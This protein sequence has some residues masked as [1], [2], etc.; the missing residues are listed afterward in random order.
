MGKGKKLV[1][2]LL[3][4][5]M[6][7]SLLAGASPFTGANA[8]E[9]GQTKEWGKDD[10]SGLRAGDTVLFGSYEQDNDLENGAE[11]IEWIA[12]SVEGDKALLLSK[13]ALE[14]SSY[15]NFYDLLERFPDG[16]GSVDWDAVKITWEECTLRAWL[17]ETF[18]SMA[19]TAEQREAVIE[20]VLENAYNPIYSTD[21]GNDTRDCV[22]LL[23]IEDVLNP[24][25]GFDESM[26]MYDV[27]RRC[28][29]T[30]YV[31]A[32]GLWTLDMAYDEGDEG[33]RD[34]ATAEGE[35]PCWWWLRSSGEDES[36]AAQ[37]H[38]YGY[39]SDDYMYDEEGAVRPAIY[40][41]LKS[42]Q[43]SDPVKKG[44]VDGDGQINSKDVTQL[45]RYLAGGWNVEINMVNADV[46][47]DGEVNSKDV[48]ILRRFLAGGWGVVL[49]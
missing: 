41:D 9:S 43:P 13:Y 47:G 44:D 39:V 15:E 3:A 37:V 6:M 28:S 18:Y 33:W 12:L 8:L 2:L 22:F 19:F 24:D 25:Y 7:T 27:A 42:S 38:C 30:E 17:N 32:Q 48:T 20:T 46:N 49:E 5:V 11:P 21:G 10:L 1:G 36:R 29:G 40:L 4:A 16:E 31:K 23:T 34:Y 35:P 14:R 26:F 45:R